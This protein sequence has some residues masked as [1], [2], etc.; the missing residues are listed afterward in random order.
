MKVLWVTDPWETLDHRNDT[1]LRLVQESLVLGHTSW[2]CDPGGIRF[3][4]GRVIA[5]CRRVRGT[6]P[7]RTAAGWEL[8]QAA[9]LSLEE[10]DAVHYRVDPP[11]D[12]RYW[13]HLQLLALVCGPAGPELINAYEAITRFGDK[14]GPTSLLDALPPTL[15]SSSWESLDA[16]GQKQGR[17]VLKPLGDAQSRGVQLLDWHSQAG[18]AQARAA[19]ERMSDGLTRPV[20][21]Q[22]FIPEVYQGE[23]RLWFVN[24]E[25]LA[26]VQKQPLEGTFVIDMD[27][28]SACRA[29][30]LS[31]A[32]AKL[33]SR[34]GHDFRANRVRLA[35]VDLIGGRVTDWNL[36][37]PGM[38]P[39]MERILERNL[40]KPIILAL[41]KHL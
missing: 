26:Y 32:E 30:E 21:L 1:T 17:L 7:E 18:T 35:A 37:S 6:E 16:F 33:A 15:V 20:L 25:L 34:I 8:D 41:A 2:W 39:T 23:K 28:G 11:V 12:R 29:C 36:T 13:E 24:G 9:D 10:L 19:V 3:E 5:R 4:V 27:K 22:Q 31:A 40:A 14:L 38:I